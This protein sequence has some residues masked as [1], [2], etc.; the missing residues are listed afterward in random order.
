MTRPHLGGPAAARHKNSTD[1]YN[2]IGWLKLSE[3]AREGH[4]FVEDMGK[5]D[6]ANALV[7]HL[8]SMEDLPCEPY[9]IACEIYPKENAIKAAKYIRKRAA[10]AGFSLLWW[11]CSR[12]RS[13]NN[14][15]LNRSKGSKPHRM[16]VAMRAFG[17]QDLVG[18]ERKPFG[19]PTV[20]VEIALLEERDQY[21]AKIK[22]HNAEIPWSQQFVDND[23]VQALTPHRGQER[24]LIMLVS[25]TAGVLESLLAVDHLRALAGIPKKKT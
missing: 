17:I 1:T 22:F 6:R 11:S 18:F 16:V 12:Y 21:G 9:V 2:Y 19:I 23:I 10:K 14:I 7:R 3:G 13:S 24:S 8:V 15:E 20:D 4:H 5:A 25:A